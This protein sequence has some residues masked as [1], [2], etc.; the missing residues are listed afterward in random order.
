MLT[1]VQAYE[2]DWSVDSKGSQTHEDES[3]MEFY[4]EEQKMEFYHQLLLTVE[5]LRCEQQHSKLQPRKK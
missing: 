1:V 3:K 4:E 5:D 2:P